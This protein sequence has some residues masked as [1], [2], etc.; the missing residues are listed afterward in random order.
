MEG[1]MIEERERDLLGEGKR[2]EVHLGARSGAG[3]GDVVTQ[4]SNGKLP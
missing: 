4:K 3:G 1:R 2:F